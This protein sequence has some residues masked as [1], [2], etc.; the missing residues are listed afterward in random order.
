MNWNAVVVLCAGGVSSVVLAAKYETVWGGIGF[1]GFTLV[2]AF[3][4]H[5]IRS[6]RA[7]NNA[8]SE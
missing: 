8:D 6:K 4:V 3:A 7:Q 2:L 1:F 5:I